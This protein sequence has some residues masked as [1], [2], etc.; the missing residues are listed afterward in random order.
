LRILAPST[1]EDARGIL[2]PALCDPDPVLIFEHAGL[3]N[4]EGELA[5]DAGPVEL[6]GAALRRRGDDVTI[7]AY[8]G[9]VRTALG[10]AEQL[11]AEGVAAD[12]IDLRSLRPLDVPTILAS[13]ARTH[14]AVVVDEGWRAG[15]LSAEVS[16]RISEGAFYDL[17][18]PVARVCSDEVPMP[19]AKHM[20]DEV[21]P[22]VADVVAAVHGLGG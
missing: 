8:G 15:S 17:D 1:V 4:M 20:E 22:Q 5:D 19:Y 7:V 18:A 2:W 11:S 12:V 10:A 14:R 6:T 16:A 9:T 3:Y 21:I 13:V